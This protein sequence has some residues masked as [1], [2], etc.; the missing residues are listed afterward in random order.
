MGAFDFC[1]KNVCGPLNEVNQNTDEVC[2]GVEVE[3]EEE[4]SGLCYNCRTMEELERRSAERRAAGE[5]E[6]E[7]EEDDEDM[8]EV[9]AP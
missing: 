1:G 8:E 3:N 5:E 7:E 2:D 4:E 9:Y 6:E